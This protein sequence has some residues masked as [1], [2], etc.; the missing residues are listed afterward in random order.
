VSDIWSGVANQ[1][2]APDEYPAPG[3]LAIAL[4]PA[5]RQTPAL[6]LI[7]QA[8]VDVVQRSED[9]EQPHLMV[10]MP[11]QE[12]KSERVSHY[13]PLWLLRKNKDLRIG[14]VSYDKSTAERWGRDIRNDINNFDGTDGQ[15]DLGMRLRTGSKSAGRWQL[16]DQRGGVYCVGIDGA[17]T[18]RPVDVL[19]VD[20]PVKNR[21]EADSEIV[22]QQAKNFWTSSAV[23]RLG[24]NA[25]VIVI[26]TRWHE[27]DLSGWLLEQGKLEPRLDYWTVINIPAQAE[28]ILDDFGNPLPNAIPDSLGREPGE[29]MVS[30]RGRTAADWEKRRL[31]VGSRDWTALYQQRP[32]PEQGNILLRKWWQY[33]DLPRA[34]KLQDGSYRTF[35]GG[36]VIQ[37]W[38]MSFKDDKGS[39]FVC[40]MVLQQ[41]DAEITVLDL[42][43]EQMDVVATCDAMVALSAK[44]PQARLKLVEDKANGPAVISILK[45]KLGGIVAYTP[46][47]SKLARTFAI[48]PF[49]EAGNIW[50]PSPTIAPW[51]S[52]FVDQCASFPNAAHDD[53]VDALTQGLTRLLLEVGHV[54][55]FMHQLL[56]ERGITVL[57]GGRDGHQGSAPAEANAR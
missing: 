17:L 48:A 54:Q 21:S 6:E 7:D 57:P 53:M 16:D 28:N 27:D 42:I 29:W 2:D 24:P 19:I 45:Q 4:N 13:F 52:A 22:R 41:N 39:D 26:Q 34:R 15:I 14:I 33:Y 11:P 44:W 5:T 3:D 30:A 25:I 43:Y 20:D 46:K 31:E 55:S 18:G 50:L 37:S 1:L 10:F 8:L 47:D 32:S 56:R 51:I 38:D 12:G 36:R 9:G 35:R 23:T 40:G 49:V